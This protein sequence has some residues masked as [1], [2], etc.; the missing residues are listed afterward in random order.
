[1][2]PA[3]SLDLQRLFTLVGTFRGNRSQR[4]HDE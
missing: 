2:Q 1:V 3:I 4:G